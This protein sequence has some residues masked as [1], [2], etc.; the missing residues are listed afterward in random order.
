MSGYGRGFSNI[1]PMAK[2]LLIAN[3]VI[4]VLWFIPPSREL[5]E[6]YGYLWF[7]GS[8]NFIASQFFT[9]MFTHGG[10]FHF[11]FNMFGLWMFGS[12]IEMVWGWKRFLNFYIICGLG[13][14][15]CH[16]GMTYVLEPEMVAN[17]RDQIRMTGASGA[18]YGLLVAYA[19]L[20]PNNKLMMIFF[21]VPIK[22]KYFVPLMIAI[23]LV[24]GFSGRHTGVAHFGHVG[25]AIAGLILCFGGRL[26]RW[27]K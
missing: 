16:I 2:N 5:V 9:Y 12:A 27:M 8:K 26:R 25:G 22:A 7:P 14:A 13:A 6:R 20:F 4:F 19:Y 1:T 3:A 15:V 10:M 11:L 23:D 17:F 24:A 21:P 18:I